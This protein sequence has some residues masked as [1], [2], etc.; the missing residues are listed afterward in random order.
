MKKLLC[1]I[2]VIGVIGMCSFI[3]CANNKTV[4]TFT[5]AYSEYPSWSAFGVAAQRGLIDER[6]G[7]MG[8]LEEKYGVDIV[9]KLMD[10]DPCITSYETGKVDAVCITNIDVAKPSLGRK[11]TAIGPTSTSDKADAVLSTKVKTIKEL[12]KIP[13][14]GLEKSVSQYV[15]YRGLQECGEN[16][17]EYQFIHLDP[18]AAAKT[19]QVGDANSKV[20]A[21]CVWN[22]FKLQTLRNRKDCAV[23]MGTKAGK[24]ADFDSGLTPKEVIDMVVVG[25]DVI[26]KPGGKDFARLIMDAYYQLNQQLAGPDHDEVVKQIGQKFSKLNLPDMELCLQETKFFS[27]P[28]AAIDLFEG[29]EFR[30]KMTNKVIPTCLAIK[31]FSDV[32]NKTPTIGYNDPTAQLNFDTSYIKNLKK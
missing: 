30:D 24:T 18:D 13:V 28:Q 21:I 27:T 19:L 4:P 16:P 10:Y 15:W 22:P 5:L 6:E 31:I 8:P 12:K 25:S 17:N 2:A 23:V 11:S 14:Y 32:G 9:L 1:A 20:Q 26:E 29:Q 3:G 7:H